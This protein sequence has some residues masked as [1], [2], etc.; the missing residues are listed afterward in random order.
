MLIKLV[1]KI[2]FVILNMELMGLFVFTFSSD[3]DPLRNSGL[4]QSAHNA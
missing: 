1:I 3:S 2:V 4:T